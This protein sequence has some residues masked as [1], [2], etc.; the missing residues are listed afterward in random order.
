MQRSC[1]FVV[2]LK[3]R[4]ATQDLGEPELTHGSLHVANLTLG[5]GGGLDPLGGFATNTAYHIR[6]GECFRC[7]LGGLDGECGRTRL[8]DA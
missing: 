6:M 8:G 1:N 5:G 7:P 4:A 2:L 3:A